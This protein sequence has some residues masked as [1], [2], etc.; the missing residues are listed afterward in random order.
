M[1]F[2]TMAQWLEPA[3]LQYACSANYLDAIDAINLTPEQQR[4]L[5]E[6]PDPMFRQTTRDFMVNQQFRRDYWVKGARRLNPL[7]QA[8]ALRAQRLI[9][10]TPRADVALKVNGAVGEAKLNEEVYAPVLDRLADHQPH[11]LDALEASLAKDKIN[12]AQLLQAVMVL[13][14]GGHLSSVQDPSSNQGQT[15]QAAARARVL[16]D[17]L[18]DKAR[19][20]GEIGFL[21]SPVTGGGVAVNR[22]QQLFL[23]ALSSG[24]AT[25][26]SWAQHALEILASQGQRLLKDGKP[27]ESLEDNLAELN[28]QAKLFAEKQ[29]PILKAL[30]VCIAV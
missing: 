17:Y 18:M 11:D 30:G 27:I 24:K 14:G 25:P 6:I 21:A 2:A 23:L 7:E 16:N 26:E 1:H 5:N 29:L 15:G 19:G 8:N 28:Q 4:F 3:K 22:F 13:Y 12:F 20:S 9:L 10:T